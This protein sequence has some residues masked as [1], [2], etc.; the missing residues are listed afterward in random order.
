MSKKLLATV[1]ALCM[2]LCSA[3]QILATSSQDSSVPDNDSGQNQSYF[4]DG[5]V[6]LPKKARPDGQGYSPEN[7]SSQGGGYTD[8]TIAP[9]EG[10]GLDLKR[11]PSSNL[12]LK[13]NTPA[14]TDIFRVIVV[15]EEPSLLDQ[16]YSADDLQNSGIAVIS[17]REAIGSY[18]DKILDR[19]L[20][21]IDEAMAGI[22]MTVSVGS[23][24]EVNYRYDTLF[25][26]A[27]LD[28][29]YGALDAVSKVK[30]RLLRVPGGEV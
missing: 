20:G 14:P 13:Q 28:M 11:D 29:P 17:E 21:A 4:G 5:H 1:L 6:A 16:G 3:P 7:G 27:S 8:V 2:L 19:I 18:Q 15:F 25:N 12:L 9:S 10:A 30:G 23:A 24:V 26:G 22:P